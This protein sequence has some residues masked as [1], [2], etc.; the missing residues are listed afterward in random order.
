V[1]ERFVGGTKGQTAQGEAFS[2]DLVELELGGA[3]VRRIGLDF[4]PHGVAFD[5][6]APLRAATFEKRG[7]GGAIV[8]LGEG[9]LERHVVP[10]PGRHFYGHAAF[11]S[12]GARL[13]VVE[14]DL[15]THRGVLTVRNARDGSFIREF[16]TYGVDPHDCVMLE[17]QRTL[18]V[19]NAG[20]AL[21]QVGE[22]LE[23]CVTFV[24]TE[25]ERL[26]QRFGFGDPKI[27]AGHVA[28]RTDRSFAVVSAPRAGLDELTSL[29]GVTLRRVPTKPSRMKEPK[30]VT[31]QLVGETLSV[32]MIDDIVVATTPNANLV[33]MWSLA[34]GKLLGT[35]SLEFPRGV[36]PTKQG[37]AVLVTYGK[38]MPR[39][40]SLELATRA[41][42]SEL[43]IASGVCS[44]SHIFAY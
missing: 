36:L 6:R 29:G 28:V 35:V 19:T 13:F 23:A 24:D 8:E 27:N 22:E 16:P 4:L 37:D 26:V 38:S 39:V 20:A 1:S 10:S 21:G 25:T 18:C 34:K 42:R 30:S 2:L 43:P 12:D 32:A 44:G 33:T 31:Q 9:R 14:S 7:P 15:R 11:S 40:T 17:D 3:K 5:P 41:P